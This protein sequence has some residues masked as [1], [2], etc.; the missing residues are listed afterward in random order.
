MLLDCLLHYCCVLFAC[1]WCLLGLLNFA[2]LLWVWFWIYLLGGLVVLR[3]RVSG[4]AWFV[5]LGKLSF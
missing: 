5:C 1:C 4:V 3:C 2:S